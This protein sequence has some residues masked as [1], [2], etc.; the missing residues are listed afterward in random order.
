MKRFTDTAIN[1]EDWYLSGSPAHR[2]FWRYILD[3]CD[4]AGILRPNFT[5]FNSTFRH[6]LSADDFLSWVN[7]DKERVRTLE[8]GRWWITGFI[9][10]QYGI[11]V[12]S[13]TSSVHK[14]IAKQLQN[15]QVVD[16]I[17]EFGISLTEALG[18]ALVSLKDKDK[19]SSLNSEL[20]NQ[21]IDSPWRNDFKI[22]VAEGE[23]AIRELW[24]DREWMDERRRYHPDLDIVVSMEKAFNDF[25]GT[26]AGWAHKKKAKHKTIDWSLTM[27]NA[28]TLKCNQVR[29][30]TNE[31]R[32]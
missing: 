9:G 28:L 7:K 29:R 14:G 30:G 2:E 17:N 31:G 6:S 21:D 12:L 8:N 20:S 16:F 11:S 15:N 26:E 1:E 18:K 19:D 23:A 3:K 25:W 13:E 24:H 4:C 32:R 10:F 22:Y 5:V 27:K